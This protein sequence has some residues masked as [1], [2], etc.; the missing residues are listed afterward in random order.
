MRVVNLTLPF[1]PH[2]PV[3]NVWPHDPPFRTERII[4]YETHG[5]RI[6]Y[7]SLHSESGTRMMTRGTNDPTAPR[8]GDRDLGELVD[9]ETVVIDIPKGELEEITARDIE[10]RVASDPD[11]RKGDALLIRT[12]WGD[13]ERYRKIGDDYATRTPHFADYGSL[14]LANLMLEKQTD[15]LAI[16]VAYIGNL[17]PYHMKP[18][19]VDLPPWLRPPFPSQECRTYMRL[20]NS[21][22][23]LRDW[24]ASRPLHK[25]GIIIAALCNAGAITKKRVRLTAL[26]LYVDR[27][28]GAP[29]T[30]VAIED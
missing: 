1:Y 10:E 30:I 19:W 3:G 7:I 16:D 4:S 25:A 20:Y 29:V 24:S 6:D 23:G 28:P 13:E 11:Y 8:I 17:A 12:G 26:P 22:K 2:M 5:A 14:R 18:E 9:R 21:E 27:A 15:I